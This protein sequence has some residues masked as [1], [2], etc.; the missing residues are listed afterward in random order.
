MLGDRYDVKRR[1]DTI[2]SLLAGAT[3]DAVLILTSGSH[4]AAALAALAAGVPVLS[5]K[6]LAYTLAEVEAPRGG[7]RPARARLHE[8]RR[9]GGRA[10]ARAPRGQDPARAVEVTVLH[11]AAAPQLAHARL[12]PPAGDVPAERLA[13]LAATPSKL[14]EQALGA[15]AP[16]LGRLYSDVLLGTIRW[17]YLEGYP[18]YREESVVH[19]LAVVRSLVGDP[20]PRARRARD[21]DADLPEPRRASARSA[22]AEGT[23][24]RAGCRRP[25]C[26]GRPGRAASSRPARRPRARTR[27]AFEEEL[28]AFHGLVTEGAPFAAG[29]AEARTDIVTCQRIVRCLAE[30][31]GLEL[32]GE[33]AAA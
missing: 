5:E 1:Y 32:G 7:G 17:H 4:A 11:P 33:A 16:E 24:S 26:R 15:G 31:R 20:D 27:P 23:G 25:G 13:A 29:V 8:A 6:P 21:S 10:A 2:D 9:P 12:D 18:A 3:V 30:R 28:V 19:E 22:R 14:E